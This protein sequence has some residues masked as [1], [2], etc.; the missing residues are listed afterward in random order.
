MKVQFA[1]S[2]RKHGI[3]KGR[4]I[5]ALTNATF[6]GSKQRQ[7]GRWTEMYVGTDSRGVELEIGIGHLE[8]GT[9]L[10]IHVMPTH[11]RKE[12]S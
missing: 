7:D 8:D 4:A 10:V 11:Y 2:A 9:A 3:A 12:R 6:I 1:K 5:E